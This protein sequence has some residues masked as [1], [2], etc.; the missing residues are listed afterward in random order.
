MDKIDQVNI[1]EEGIDIRKW[2]LFFLRYWHLFVL[3]ILLAQLLVFLIVSFSPRQYEVS[4]QILIRNDKN[5]LDK[6]QMFTSA[7]YDPYKT[8]NEKG[9]LRSK[10]V[11][12]NAL[13]KLDFYTGYFELNKFRKI[14]L[15]NQTP[16]I[17]S[18]DTSHLQPLNLLFTVNFLN[19]SLIVIK[20]EGDNVALYDFATERIVKRI[21]K[22]RFED[23]ARFGQVTGNAFCRFTL[24]PGYE[25]LSK[26]NI[27][28]TF[29]FQFY[30][31]N[32][33]IGMYRQFK[34]DNDRVSSMINV[35]LRCPNPLKGADFLNSLT[36]EY[37]RKGM[38]RDNN[39]AEATIRFIDAQL[40]DIV[41]SL[42]QSSDRLQIFKSSNKV[43]DIGFQA[44]KVYN[45]I[46]ELEAEK[47]KLLVRKRYF[48]YLLE[49]LKS[50]AE[51][52]DLV[53]PGGLDISDPVLNKLIM[54]LSTLYSDRAELSF[55]SV[56]NNPYINSLELK[57]NDTR[58]KLAET[59]RT[60][61][62]ATK[63]SIDETELLIANTEK[64]LNQLPKEQQKFLNIERKFKLN[65]EL[66]TYLLTRRS[67]MEIFKASNLPA[68]DLIDSADPND[69][70]LVS[71][72][73]KASTMIAL[74][75]GIFLPATI[76]YIRDTIN[77]KIRTREDIQR[78]TK[79]PIVGQIIASRAVSVPAVISEPNSLLSESY[80]TLR[81]NLQFVIDESVSNAIL[82][83]SA[84]QGE[85]K[86]FTALNLAAIY[87]F[88]GKKTIL[89]DFDLRKSSINER[90]KLN[91]ESGLSNYLSKNATF[92]NIIIKNSKINFDLI[93]AGPV[94]PNPSELVAS[95][96]T[97]ELFSRL[98]REYDII[99]V[100]SPPVGIVSDAIMI[101]PH[102]DVSL[103]VVRYNFTHLDIFE[104]T[105][106]D[107]KEKKIDKVNI[108]L[109]DLEISKGRYGYGYGY[110]YGY[111]K[112]S[113]KEG[114]KGRAK[115]LVSKKKR[116]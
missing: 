98:K 104:N 48:T 30:S 96:L 112:N 49:N 89:V 23:T 13:R 90:L 63:I 88:Y 21:N 31:I 68:N 77:N 12:R 78:L 33:L 3:S 19:D 93:V 87:S 111:S 18:K 69:A 28:K 75:L 97:L 100:D 39:K 113:L 44:E 36:N 79:L 25:F 62:D 94:P 8:E 84:R 22:F 27:H 99:I 4:A 32:Q 52:S 2:F 59:A 42:H 14:E 95:S 70:I 116:A 29:Y 91:A 7:L 101:Y 58:Q 51:I 54:E 105:I 34:I 83:T 10:S 81:T 107:I 65:D 85:G 38:E 115:G 66:Y 56:Q 102:T 15:Y 64:E 24:M 109:N 20:S 40:I 46:E 47:S 114:K 106:N 103:L 17:I 61:L 43:L 72:N 45:K 86:S 67:E 108:V 57:I 110:G 1:E 74:L 16:F 92:E 26:S 11:T 71:P 9:I 73:K 50:K 55:N 5:P 76:L 80:R 53:V 82:V 6:E 41:D 35:K 37:L 60:I